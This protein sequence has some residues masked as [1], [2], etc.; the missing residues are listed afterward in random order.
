MIVDELDTGVPVVIVKG[1]HTPRGMCQG[2]MRVGV[3][4][5]KIYPPQTLTLVKGMRVY[6]GKI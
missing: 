2:Y 3:R 4:V 6:L 1:I 5:S